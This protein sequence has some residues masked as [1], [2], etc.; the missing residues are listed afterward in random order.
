[1]SASMN[2]NIIKTIATAAKSNPAMAEALKAVISTTNPIELIEALRGDAASKKT[3]EDELR[4]LLFNLLTAAPAM[5]DAAPA[6]TAAAVP[7]ATSAEAA[8]I[9]EKRPVPFP[10]LKAAK[11]APPMPIPSPVLSAADAAPAA[12]PQPRATVPAAYAA[13]AGQVRVFKKPSAFTSA[14]PRVPYHA[15]AWAAYGLFEQD[16]RFSAIAGKQIAKRTDCFCTIAGE[17]YQREHRAP[18]GWA[19]L[20]LFQLSMKAAHEAGLRL[21]AARVQDEHGNHLPTAWTIEPIKQLINKSPAA[22]AA[23]VLVFRTGMM[24]KGLTISKTAVVLNWATNETGDLYFATQHVVEEPDAKQR[25]VVEYEAL[26]ELAAANYDINN[27]D[28]AEYYVR[29]YSDMVAVGA[30]LFKWNPAIDLATG[31]RFDAAKQSEDDEDDD[32]EEQAP[33]PA[34]KKVKKVKKAN[35][36]PK[37]VVDAE[38]ALETSQNKYAALEES[39]GES[40]SEADSEDE[41]EHSLRRGESW[42]DANEAEARTE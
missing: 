11:Q 19:P 15:A 5:P 3:V 39:D 36:P 38:P 6:A 18:S 32:E 34:S 24:E 40:D 26:V 13:T 42:A 12:M 8:P 28:L 16:S 37:L 33:A 2:I 25:R 17:T 21:D 10:A 31:K 20:P 23:L 22:G 4:A 30:G 29:S 14:K 7:A 35:K 27:T 9:A 1:M 41:D